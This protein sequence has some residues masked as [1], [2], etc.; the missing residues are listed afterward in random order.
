M[1]GHMV[2][3]DD[4]VEVLEVCVVSVI[5]ID[6]SGTL[7][8]AFGIFG[9]VR[10]VVFLRFDKRVINTGAIDGKPTHDV[11]IHCL[12]FGKA[13]LAIFSGRLEGLVLFAVRSFVYLMRVPETVDGEDEANKQREQSHVIHSPAKSPNYSFTRFIARIRHRPDSSHVQVCNFFKKADRG[14]FGARA[15]PE[16]RV[17][18]FEA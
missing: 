12:Q 1:L 8:F 13:F 11:T 3:V 16:P 10:K 18:K 14:T 6:A 17:S 7:P 4:G 9:E 5:Y 15:L 2:A